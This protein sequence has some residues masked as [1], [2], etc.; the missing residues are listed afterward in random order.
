MIFRIKLACLVVVFLNATLCAQGTEVALRDLNTHCPFTPPQSLGAWESR[1]AD[2]KLQLQIALGLYPAI[3]L[4]PVQPK[5]YGRVERDDYTIEKVTFESLPGF[6][7]TGNLYRPKEIAPNTKVPAVLAPHGHWD[8][9][10]FYDTSP[11]EVKKLLADGSERFENAARNHIQARCVQLARMGCIVFHWDMI[12]YCDNQQINSERAHRFAKQPRES[13]V[14]AAGWLLFSP[15]AE[16]H[17]QSILGLQ[18]LAIHRAVDMLLALPE[19][20]PQRI[21]ISGA[22]GGGT[23]SFLGAATDPRISLAFPAVMV[24]TGMQGGC[25]CENACLLRIGTG[26]V[27]M[28]ALIA[29]RPLGLTAANDWTKNMPND[30]FPELQ[31]LYD[32]FGAKNKV[33]LF[34]AVHF[35]HNFNHV[36]RVGLYGW[37]NDHFDLGF[38]KPVLER[39]F[40]IALRDEL[41]VW[42]EAHPQPE[43]GEDFERRLLKLW[44]E[45]LDRQMTT[46]L[47]GDAAQVTQLAKT[48]SDGWR[49]CLGLTTT[50]LTTPRVKAAPSNVTIEFEHQSLSKWDL[51]QVAGPLTATTEK[52]SVSPSPSSDSET[53]HH[54]IME[55]G[56]PSDAIRIEVKT[57]D[58]TLHFAPDLAGQQSSEAKNE[59]VRLQAIVE[60]PRLAAAFTYGYNLPLF[61]QRAQQLGLTL[62]WL[63]RQNPQATITLHGSGDEAALAA[64]GTFVAQQLAHTAK[65]EP[66]RLQL[67]LAPADFSFVQVD[68]IRHPSFLPAAARYWDLPGLIACTQATVNLTGQ[69]PEKSAAY[70]KLAPLAKQI[71]TVLKLE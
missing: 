65:E 24:S 21:A 1:A 45:I 6:L 33:A 26:N 13:E 43:G 66:L 28:A 17:G 7:V 2:L 12:G 54:A 62:R 53:P 14:N 55:A 31:K 38:E 57:S 67:S 8:N 25:T 20:D 59:Q 30:G 27:E 23:Q 18:T 58:A 50:T 36:S 44:A 34:P 29:P 60:N 52:R 4:D 71:G 5:I 61:A 37:I 56:Q 64:A 19:V 32:L 40:D 41:T 42:D 48:L 49:V 10:R 70:R 39:D 68:S 69:P 15:P 46:Q 63:A 3:E 22:S 11:A 9:A 16:A 47:Q 51:F 35:G